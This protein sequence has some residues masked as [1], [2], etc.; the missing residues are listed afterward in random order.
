[1]LRIPATASCR[2]GAR[3]WTAQSPSCIV[4]SA[5]PAH[6]N[7]KAIEE[8]RR[9][10]VAQRTFDRSLK[11]RPT[12]R[13]CP[14]PLLAEMRQGVPYWGAGNLHHSFERRV[15]RHDQEDRA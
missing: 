10:L 2:I 3:I 13:T 1:M 11:C 6:Q 9:I 8:V 15:H 4:P 14:R 5:H 12:V 7:P